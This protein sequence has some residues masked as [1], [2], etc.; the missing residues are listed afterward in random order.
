MLR[1]LYYSIA[2]TVTVCMLD[3]AAECFPFNNFYTKT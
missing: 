2:V 3:A 1:L